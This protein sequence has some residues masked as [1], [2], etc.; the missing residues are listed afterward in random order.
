VPLT[1]SDCVHACVLGVGDHCRSGHFSVR[2]ADV[3]LPNG[4]VVQFEV[5]FGQNAV[6]R[7]M[8]APPD[9]GM[10]QVNLANENTRVVEMMKEETPAKKAALAE[11]A[12]LKDEVAELKAQLAAVQAKPAPNEGVPPPE[13]P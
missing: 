3:R 6:S 8:P 13:L 10:I 2:I 1:A 5:R 12:E 4:T 7:K 9:S 11:V